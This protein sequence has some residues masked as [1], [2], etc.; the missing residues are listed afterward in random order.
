MTK[1]GPK[2]S[3]VIS[4]TIPNKSQG[5]WRVFYFR[6]WNPIVISLRSLWRPTSSLKLEHVLMTFRYSSFREGVGVWMKVMRRKVNLRIFQSS[7]WKQPML[8]NMHSTQFLLWCYNLKH[9]LKALIKKVK[10]TFYIYC[11]DCSSPLSINL[12]PLKQ[13]VQFGTKSENTRV[14]TDLVNS[15]LLCSNGIVSIW[16][17]AQSMHVK[18]YVKISGHFLSSEFRG[19]SRG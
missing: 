13:N 12:P 14:L 9:W 5:P 10:L 16:V 8:I 15:I 2:S 3:L 4:W 7:W 17:L 19:T 11:T 6:N 1:S 18:V